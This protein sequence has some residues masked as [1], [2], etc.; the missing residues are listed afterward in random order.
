MESSFY[1]TLKSDKSKDLFNNKPA[2]FSNYL[3]TEINIAA[4]TYECGIAQLYYTP[5]RPSDTFTCFATEEEK[6]ITYFVRDL[7]QIVKV[8]SKDSDILDPLY[9]LALDLEQH[10]ITLKSELV[11]GSSTDYLVEFGFIA[12]DKKNLE[13]EIPEFYSAALGFNENV[14]AANTPHLSENPMSVETYNQIEDGTNIIFQIYFDE[15][16]EAKSQEPKHYVF[17]EFIEAINLALGKTG[18]KIQFSNDNVVFTTPEKY[19]AMFYLTLSK[20]MLDLLGMSEETV[21]NG[22]NSMYPA[23]GPIIWKKRAKHH[24]IHTSIVNPRNFADKGEQILK[25]LPIPT[26]TGEES[27]LI[28]N[29]V[30]YVTLKNTLKRFDQ[31][32]I[33]ITDEN[34]Q[35]A[36][37][38]GETTIELHLRW[39]Q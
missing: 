10:G 12:K 13:L 29:P 18:V 24:L 4:D 14:F 6:K 28:F 2:K 37:L 38:D 5:K 39:R 8:K 17:A 19:Q 36:L 33:W 15:N 25:M 16:G 30:Q 11:P 34:L 1:V 23:L 20:R 3:K 27:T 32:E 35:E 26:V 7:L 21:M 9:K 22:N 31:I